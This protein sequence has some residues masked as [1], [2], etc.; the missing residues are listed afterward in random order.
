MSGELILNFENVSSEILNNYKI[1]QAVRGVV[2]GSD[3]KIALINFNKK[4]FYT[5]P[6]GGIENSETPE[7]A[8]IRECVE[9][10]GCKT[11][12]VEYLGKV[13]EI[14]KENLTQNITFG[15]TLKVL[16]GLTKPLEIASDSN[17]EKNSEIIWVSL[18]QALDLI[19]VNPLS[20]N[21]YINYQS[22][23]DLF[24]VIQALKI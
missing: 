20:E 18:E 17:I 8:I 13:T 1:R 19:G 21:L 10:I 5:L 15:F 9:E 14:R 24:F 7:S 12:V 4:N 16:G 22:Q 23:R 2:F 11:E 6:G 3:N